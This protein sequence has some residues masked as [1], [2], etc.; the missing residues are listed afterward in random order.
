[1]IIARKNGW[2]I[3]AEL[4]SETKDYYKLQPFDQ[5]TVVEVD[6]FSETEKVFDNVY[7]AVEWIEGMN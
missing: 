1:M 3:S 2:L 6:K 5:K 7:E 4:I